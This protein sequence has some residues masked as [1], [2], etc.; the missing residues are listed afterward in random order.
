M[1]ELTNKSAE[2]SGR[3]RRAKPA[4]RVD[5]TAMVDLA[6][7]LI[8]FFMLTTS[9]AKPHV[10]GITMPVKD[11]EPGTVSEERTITI[12]LGKDNQ[13]QWYKGTIDHPLI[14]PVNTSYGNAGIRKALVEQS[15]EVFRK[16]GKGLIVLIKPGDKSKYSNL[17][18]ILD[19]MK[20]TKI[21]AYAIE[22]ISGKELDM[23][24][25]GGMY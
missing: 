20:I 23:L 5:L 10:M 14:G 11:A 1:A 13:L 17:V 25:K 6:F 12:C 3:A 7:L 16:T 4:P 24:S 2:G 22:D 8:T 9:L 21:P 18:D 19:E 15:R